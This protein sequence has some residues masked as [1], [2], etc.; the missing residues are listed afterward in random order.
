MFVA[1]AALGFLWRGGS[2]VVKIAI[3]QDSWEFKPSQITLLNGKTNTLEI[4]NED[5]YQHGF[6]IQGLGVNALLPANSVTKVE[7]KPDKTG[8]F[9]FSCSFTCGAGHYRMTGEVIVK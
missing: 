4:K 8:R 2:E 6:Y 1:L 9:M 3:P 5:N 7:V